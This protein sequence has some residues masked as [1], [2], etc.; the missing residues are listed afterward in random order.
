MEQRVGSS[1]VHMNLV[2]RPTPFGIS[3]VFIHE[4][5]CTFITRATFFHRLLKTL[6]DTHL[7]SI[8]TCLFRG[9]LKKFSQPIFTLQLN[10]RNLHFSLDVEECLMEMDF[11][12]LNIYNAFL[13]C[14]INLVGK[15]AQAMSC[16]L[17][18]VSSSQQIFHQ[19]I[20][21]AIRI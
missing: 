8:P 14:Y 2:S 1:S 5:P 16:S 7:L 4:V 20:L 12:L 6:A 18:S 19:D 17:V 13:M 10:K 9:K 3:F 15:T 21:Y 11:V